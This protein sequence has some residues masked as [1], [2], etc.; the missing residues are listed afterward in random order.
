[1]RAIITKGSRVRVVN[2]TAVDVKDGVKPN[3]IGHVINLGS[4]FITVEF[5]T[6]RRT[7]EQPMY[8]EQL[9]VI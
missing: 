5:K 8:P 1:M 7:I 2:A 6:D 4:S 9:R 3:M